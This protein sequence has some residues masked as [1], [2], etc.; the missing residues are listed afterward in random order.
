M[1]TVTRRWRKSTRSTDNGQCVE[2]ANRLDAMR[3]SKTPDGSLLEW[4]TSAFRAFLAAAKGGRFD[5]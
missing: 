4:P 3:D 2:V 1:I 5:G